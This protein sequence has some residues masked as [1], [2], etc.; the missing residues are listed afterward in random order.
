[1][2][3]Q[4]KT[5]QP[6]NKQQNKAKNKLTTKP[7]AKK[8]TLAEKQAIKLK[9]QRERQAKKIAAGEIE[10]KNKDRF[11][12]SSA[13]MQAELIKWRDSNKEEEERILKEWEALPRSVR[14]KTPKPEIDY[15]K[16][17]LSEEF[18]KMLIAI[19]DK[20]LNRSE[21]RNYSKEIKE[22]A[23]G[24]FFLKAIKGLRNYNFEFNNPFAY[25]STCAWNAYISTISKH[26]KHQN[27]KK[28]II[29]QMLSDLETYS[30][31]DPHSSLNNYIR[32]YIENDT[33]GIDI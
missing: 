26:Y 7:V 17:H 24:L 5:A 30:G 13:E 22:D 9:I 4:Q 23:K 25:F 32:Q 14:D 10:P 29:M 31:I 12:C 6:K 8:L 27:I 3:K 15:G 11:Y 20:M 21:F 33:Y 19:A 18:G 2:K 16:R 28:D 1:M